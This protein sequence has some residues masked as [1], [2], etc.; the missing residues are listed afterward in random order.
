MGDEEP[1]GDAGEVLADER[2]R[3]EQEAEQELL[4]QGEW[5]PA[6][7]PGARVVR[8]A[9]IIWIDAIECA[10][11]LAL[12]VVTRGCCCRCGVG[13]EPPSQATRRFR[14]AEKSTNSSA[15]SRARGAFPTGCR[16]RSR[17]ILSRPPQRLPGFATRDRVE[18]SGAA[19][20]RKGSRRSR[21]SPPES[22]R[23]G[24]S[25][26]LTVEAS[27]RCMQTDDDGAG[28]HSDC[29]GS[30]AAPRGRRRRAAALRAVQSRLR[31]RVTSRSPRDEEQRR[32][33][34][35]RERLR[36]ELLPVPD[37][38][39]GRRSRE[40]GE[41][42]K[43][44]ALAERQRAEEGRDL[45][46]V[47]GPDQGRNQGAP[48]APAGGRRLSVRAAVE[49]RQ[50]E[51]AIGGGEPGAA[52]V[53]VDRREIGDAVGLAVFAAAGRRRGCGVHRD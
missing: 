35:C 25:S 46:Q 21:R 11:E 7:D 29:G 48:A 22:A 27:S 1:C 44:S 52:G 23:A 43:G 49:Q 36:R 47:A 53:G 26:W 3:S 9:L 40:V 14:A 8:G 18:R 6:V 4:A 34:P 13:R 17:V 5:K 30:A 10:E 50:D 45:G 15:A 31:T 2:R 12:P 38:A 41:E 51:A 20:A 32:P 37:C 42:A 28:G 33:L 16:L 19:G 39:E 24:T